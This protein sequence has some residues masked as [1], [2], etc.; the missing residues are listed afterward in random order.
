MNP[1]PQIPSADL[2][3]PD[4]L[5]ANATA[6]FSSGDSTLFRGAIL[7]SITALEA[8]VHRTV[9]NSLQSKLDPLLVTWLDEKTRMDFGSRLS[10][11]TPV[12]TGLPIDKSSRF[13]I[14]YKKAK[15]IR[16]K[17]STPG[18]KLPQTISPRSCRRCAL[19]SPII[20]LRAMISASGSE[21][22]T[23]APASATPKLPVNPYSRARAATC[24]RNL[25][26]QTPTKAPEWQPALCHSQ[27]GPMN[28]F[29]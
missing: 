25:S 6:M 12:A 9:F 28:F 14:A 13:W 17:S 4:E 19:G 22:S 15:D 24:S 29:A 5:L 3:T 23:V 26:F 1:A 2:H 8:F 18:G 11:L 10:V 27:P 16:K 7:E 21:C 20:V